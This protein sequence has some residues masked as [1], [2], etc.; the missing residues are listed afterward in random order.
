[1]FS[2][3]DHL[4]YRQDQGQIHQRGQHLGE[5]LKYLTIIA[6]LDSLGSQLR[7]PRS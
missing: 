4:Q 7:C 6:I 3:C 1:M 2:E 5:I